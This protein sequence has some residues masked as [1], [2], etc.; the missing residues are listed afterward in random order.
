MSKQLILALFSLF[1]LSNAATLTHAEVEDC[2]AYLSPD[3][4]LP[5]QNL[6]NTLLSAKYDKQGDGSILIHWPGTGNSTSPIH[7]N[8]EVPIE[9]MHSWHWQVWSFGHKKYLYLDFG[10]KNLEREYQYRAQMILKQIQ[11]NTYQPI[12]VN[13]DPL[14]TRDWEFITALKNNVNSQVLA[15]YEEIK[16]Y[17]TENDFTVLSHINQLSESND[18]FA[19]F[20]ADILPDHFESNSPGE[21]V[22]KLVMSGQIS[23]Y[24]NESFRFA[25]AENLIEHIHP[26]MKKNRDRHFSFEERLYGADAQRIMALLQS[27]FDLHQVTEIT[28]FAKLSKNLPNAVRDRLILQMFN[29]QIARQKK[30]FIATLDPHTYRLFSAQYGFQKI[31]NLPERPWRPAEILA[32]LRVDSEEFKKGKFK[33][34]ES[35]SQVE[36]IQDRS[37]HWRL[38]NP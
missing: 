7:L 24:G 15:R 31:L 33:L 36:S 9:M 12:L 13:E 5:T 37:L 34:Q 23:Y 2:S 14:R 30:V 10:P 28:R 27:S 1:L 17:L 16:D 3:L 38:K 4:L 18:I 6:L 8:M 32:F 20:E 25:N 21:L 29:K 19:L 35:A 22:K 26:R 11:Q